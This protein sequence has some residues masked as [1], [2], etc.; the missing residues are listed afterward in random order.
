[1]CEIKFHGKRLRVVPLA[2]LMETPATS[3][4]SKPKLFIT[5]KYTSGNDRKSSAI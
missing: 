5:W 3:S 4:L 2:F 1:V